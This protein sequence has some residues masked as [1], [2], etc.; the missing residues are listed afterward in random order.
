[1]KRLIAFLVVAVM[2]FTCSFTAVAAELPV[3]YDDE[4]QSLEERLISYGV[5][6]LLLDALDM[7]SFEEL[8]EYATE[9]GYLDINEILGYAYNYDMSDTNMHRCPPSSRLCCIELSI[10]IV[11]CHTPLKGGGFRMGW[12]EF[13]SSCGV[14]R[15][16]TDGNFRCFCSEADLSYSKINYFI[17]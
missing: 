4:C 3:Q 7:E 12:V 13:C 17:V 6:D 2:V 14:A 5:L 16:V 10:V 1:M 9:I 15:G 11:L 8:M